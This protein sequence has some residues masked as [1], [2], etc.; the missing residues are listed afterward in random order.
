MIFLM[1]ELEYLNK[2]LDWVE[3]TT[4]SDNQEDEE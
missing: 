1:S 4:N 3:Q 2:L